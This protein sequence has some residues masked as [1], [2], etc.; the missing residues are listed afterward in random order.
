MK[1]LSRDFPEGLEYKIAYNPTEFIADS[2]HELM[3]DL[4]AMVW[5]FWSSSFFCKASERQSF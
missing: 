4:Q 3:D 5:S 1:R 2:I